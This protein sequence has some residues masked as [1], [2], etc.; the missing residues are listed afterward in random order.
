MSTGA[1][2]NLPKPKGTTNTG[3]DL[4]ELGSSLQKI[5][6]AVGDLNQTT[7]RY[8]VQN[9][10]GTP[11]KD[12]LSSILPNLQIGIPYQMLLMSSGGW[13]NVM[14]ARASQSY[15]SFVVYGYPDGGA[16]THA[17]LSNGNWIYK[18]LT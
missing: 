18:V 13:R 8:L 17:V 10:P 3:Q 9:A 6:D 5:N 4:I 1:P 12:H 15:A 2:L 7:V 16:V 11:W 14:G